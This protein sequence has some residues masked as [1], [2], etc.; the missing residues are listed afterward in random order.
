[1]TFKKRAL[2][3]ALETRETELTLTEVKA[4]FLHEEAR[5]KEEENSLATN[6]L[7]AN[8][9]HASGIRNS[10][11]KCKVDSRKD[12]RFRYCNKLGHWKRDFRKLKFEQIRRNKS[13]GSGEQQAQAVTSNENKSSCSGRNSF[14]LQAFISHVV[15]DE[16]I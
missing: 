14:G 1:M 5:M 3:V 10:H 11:Q 16:S 8:N 4:T 12:D 6:A 15:K 9:P 7:F 13:K 2:V